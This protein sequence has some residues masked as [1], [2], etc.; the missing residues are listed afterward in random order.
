MG[1]VLAAPSVAEPFWAEGAGMWRHGYTYSGHAAV[2]AA[3]LANLD[4][5]EREDLCGRALELETELFDA[6]G[7]LGD[8]DLVH[9]VRGGTGVLA[10]V[11]LSPGR[12]EADP[13]LPARVAAG[14]RSAGLLVRPLVG[15]TIAVSPPLIVDAA[16]LAEL[17]E[18]LRA[19]LDACR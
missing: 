2:A 19:G 6:V 11:Q 1:A 15:G 8:H 16:D 13:A 14:C 5:L 9:E 10:A 4:I 7:S 17:T 18:G 3:A 12:V